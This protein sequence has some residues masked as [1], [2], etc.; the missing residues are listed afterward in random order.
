MEKHRQQTYV[1]A[2]HWEKDSKIT[3]QTWRN[4]N[5]SDEKT[6]YLTMILRIKV[7]SQ[8]YAMAKNRQK[9]SKIAWQIWRNINIRMIKHNT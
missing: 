4:I 9:D 2:K 3:W 8:T 5:N 7:G 1:M 6:S